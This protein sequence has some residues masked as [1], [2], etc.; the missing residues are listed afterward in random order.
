MISDALGAGLSTTDSS[1]SVRRFCFT[2]HTTSDTVRGWS[3]DATPA[4]YSPV[5]A[6]DK[7]VGIPRTGGVLKLP[8]S[9]VAHRQ[10]DTTSCYNCHGSSYGADGNNVHNPTLGNYDPTVHLAMLTP[11]TSPGIY[12]IDGVAYGPLAC[13][14]CH[15][16]ELGP[17]HSKASSSSAAAGCSACHPNPRS[18]LVPSWDRTSCV[19][20]GCHTQSSSAPQHATITAAHERL[21]SN[22]ACFA[23]GCHAE[24]NLASIHKNVTATIG[25]QERR[26]CMV[27]HAAGVPE[28]RDCTSCH[29]DKAASHYDALL[30]TA[31]LTSG[32]ITI[33]GTSFGSHA[34][35]ECHVSAELGAMHTDGCSTCHPTAAGSAKPWDKSC[36]TRGCHGASAIKP[37]HGSVDA[38]HTIGEQTCTEPGCHTGAGN[39]AALHAKEGCETCHGTGKTPTRTCTATGCHANM[40]GHGD[41]STIHASNITSDWITFFE[42]SS[43]HAYNESDRGTEVNVDCTMCHAST[44]LIALHANDCSICHFGSS[45]PVTSFATWD[46]GCSQGSCHPSYHD[47]ASSGHDSV[48]N[49]ERKNSVNC[50]SDSACHK[51]GP[52]PTG[53]VEWDNEPNTLSASAAWCGSCHSVGSDTTPPTSSSNLLPSYVGTASVTIEGKD[54]RSL[55]ATYFRLDG[56]ATQTVSGTLF[57]SPPATGTQ[58]HTLEYWSTDWSGNIESPHQNAM[59]V[60]AADTVAPV[61][62]SDTKP[63]YGGPVAIHLSATD[64]ATD[65]GVRATYFR[66]DDGPDTLGTTAVVP[67]PTG[68]AETHTLYFWSV[69]YA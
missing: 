36:V 1:D 33:L 9:V 3:S 67:A 11:V 38:S 43:D 59:F 23:A 46:K 31:T 13:T 6:D 52:P 20:G 37:M 62:S 39:I 41:V 48:Y 40:D 69:D 63:S 4:T 66:L 21:A 27:C 22:D 42:D 25:G 35:S 12:D 24:G 28:S 45:P 5:A 64:N 7:V 44:N 58:T 68:D 30:H 51:F 32:D 19:Q 26:G 10:N 57:V 2:C 34:C 16:E 54:D 14:E 49:T 15:S 18:S 55:K 17:E 50:S 53:P 29:P 61:T 65:F 8:N 60:V 56:R 47:T